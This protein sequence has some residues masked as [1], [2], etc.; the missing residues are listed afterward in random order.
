MS[1]VYYHCVSTARTFGGKPEDYASLNAFLDS[2]KEW[3]PDFRH[4][5]LRHHSLGI[6]D[7]E[8]HFGLTITNSAGKQVPVRAVVELHI[9][10]DMGF[11]ATVADWLQ[12]LH[13][14]SWMERPSRHPYYHALTSADTFGG[15]AHDYLAAHTWL[16]ATREALADDRHRA[17]RYHAHGVFEG[18]RQIGTTILNSDQVHVPVRA[19]LEAQIVAEFGFVPTVSDWLEHIQPQPWMARASMIKNAHLQ[20][21]ARRACA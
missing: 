4:R 14:Q 18:E 6:F 8:R 15:K 9:L 3:Y 2:P 11:L 19:I 16:E 20:H 21:R 12:H 10:E 13:P 7:A 5:A 17:L 1:H